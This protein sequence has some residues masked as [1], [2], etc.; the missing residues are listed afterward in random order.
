LQPL[1]DRA[2][3]KDTDSQVSDDIDSQAGTQLHEE[4][5]D[6]IDAEK[7]EGEANIVIK[8]LAIP[9]DCP[10]TLTELKV[11]AGIMDLNEEEAQ[12]IF[13]EICKE[14][15]VAFDPER[16][17]PMIEIL[18]ELNID[19]DDHEGI[20]NFVDALT[21]ARDELKARPDS[22]MGSRS[23]TPGGGACERQMFD[24]VVRDMDLNQILGKDAWKYVQRRI[25][26]GQTNPK[27]RYFSRSERKLVENFQEK[28]K[29]FVEQVQQFMAQPPTLSASAGQVAAKELCVREVNEIIQRCKD[30]GTQYTDPDW[31]M[32]SYPNKV[33]Y[34][35]EEQP[36]YDCTV[37][38]P[39]RYKRLPQIVKKMSSGGTMG[40]LGGMFG[41]ARKPD[42]KKPDMKPVVFKGE[43]TAGDIIQG[44]IG[45]CFLLGAIG[46]MACH[47]AQALPKIFV[48]HDVDVGVYGVRFCLDGEWTHV[49]VDDVFPVDDGGQL[50]YAR[51]KDPQ[52]VWVPILEKAFCKLHTCYEMCDGGEATEALN[53]F[54]GGVTGKMVIKPHHH[55]N[56]GKF[57]N[58]LKNARDKGWLLATSFVQRA[59]STSQGNGKCGEAIMEGGLV[60]GHAYSV[61]KLV[62][63]SGHQLI[64]CRNPWGSGEWTGS[65][66]DEDPAWTPQLRKACGAA[67]LDDGK[68]WMS[69]Q[70]FVNNSG[71]VEYARSFGPNWKKSTQYA[72]FAHST[73]MG[74]AK[75]DCKGKR[76][77][78]LSFSKGD[79]IRI[80]ETQGQI[81]FGNIKGAPKVVGAFPGRYVKFNDRPVLRFDIMATPAADDEDQQVTAVVM[82]MQ[83]N[84]MMK[85]KF[86]AMP[87][88]GGQNYKDTNYPHIE[89]IVVDPE[90]KVAIRKKG[91]KRCVW[92]EVDMPG[93]GSWKIYA[94]CSSGEGAPATCRTYLKGGTLSFKEVK[95]AK[96]SEI[97]HVFFGE[98]D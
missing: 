45:T 50:L 76:G 82:L 77:N 37:T 96:F 1:R 36:G 33:L 78:M 97:A 46:A 62:E 12:E 89:L 58:L 88:F 20:E 42:A 61:L 14:K 95:G 9:L 19:V 90:G 94:I 85:R 15:G 86:K 32:Q 80:K 17:W 67:L 31:D 79:Q 63:V 69:I 26:E 22:Q 51:C 4:E 59:G 49:I 16:A 75:R 38:L 5:D 18:E 55:H 60:G 2:P 25:K 24:K 71:G 39:A 57:F 73:L 40:A 27:G 43:I 87:E 64:Q 47:R 74:T 44:Q 65:W 35:D 68:F 13:E 30:E 72:H 66:S 81:F 34:V 29:V 10:V 6:G 70:D 23:K 11:A 41:G 48:K 56:P 93:G 54:F 83:R 28:P 8:K 53:S 52:E 92:G 84:I 91:H 21:K 7:L 3:R 98:D